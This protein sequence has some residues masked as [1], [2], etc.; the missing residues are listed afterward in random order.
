ML[1]GTIIWRRES[2]IEEA[3]EKTPSQEVV[4]AIRRIV[5]SAYTGFDNEGVPV[6]VERSGMLDLDRLLK[7]GATPEDLIWTHIVSMEYFT[8][9]LCLE[10]SIMKDE[11][12][13]K[14]NTV[15]DVTGLSITRFTNSKFVTLFKK[16]S[17]IDQDNYPEIMKTV[18]IVNAPTVFNFVFGIISAFLDENTRKKIQ[19]L[20]PRDAAQVIATQMS[21]DIIPECAFGF[22]SNALL[23]Q[24]DGS[25]PA[26]HHKQ[27]ALILK[28]KMA[29]DAGDAVIGPNCFSN[30]LGEGVPE[31]R[32]MSVSDELTAKD[33]VDSGNLV[34]EDVE[35]YDARRFSLDDSLQNGDSVALVP[36]S[37]SAPY[38]I[39]DM[40]PEVAE[41]LEIV[42]RALARIK[43]IQKHRDQIGRAHSPISPFA[44]LERNSMSRQSSLEVTGREESLT[45]RQ[46]TELHRGIPELTEYETDPSLP[47]LDS[48]KSGC[49]LWFST[50]YKRKDKT[51]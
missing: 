33:E 27:D 25:V 31:F 2:N 29:K 35:F 8:N 11:T 9:V 17:K 10:A 46:S 23:C 20:G 4:N 48:V 26:T 6:Y 42:E 30:I 43:E 3:L 32:I 14:V 12:I 37:S 28:Y 38:E 18:Y 36:A 34:S 24:P 13:D 40:D 22:G 21:L 51:M 19:V 47:P 39:E 44:A 50:K 49:C 1:R 45:K 7:G 41:S 15:M 5:S 16:L